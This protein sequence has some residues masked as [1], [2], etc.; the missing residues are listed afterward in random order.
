MLTLTR[1][2]HRYITEVSHLEQVPERKTGQPVNHT[3]DLT[4]GGHSTC[5][6]KYVQL[7]SEIQPL[8]TNVP[9]IDYRIAKNVLTR[10]NKSTRNNRSHIIKVMHQLCPKISPKQPSHSLDP[11]GKEESDSGEPYQH[12][13]ALKSAHPHVSWVR[14]LAMVRQHAILL[15]S[16]LQHDRTYQHQNVFRYKSPVR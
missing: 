15:M 9:L 1:T 6:P 14:L 8:Y 11:V 7:C 4:N 2:F 12:D 5:F 3:K 10:K 16:S 13:T